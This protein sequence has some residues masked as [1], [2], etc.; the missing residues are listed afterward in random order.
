MKSL[1]ISCNSSLDVPCHLLHPLQCVYVAL[2]YTVCI[3]ILN[4]V[5]FHLEFLEVSWHSAT[6]QQ[7]Y[8]VVKGK[9]HP[10]TGHEVPEKE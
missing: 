4:C 3:C 8:L 10:I 5:I 1:V 2:C 7:K 9:V 6:V